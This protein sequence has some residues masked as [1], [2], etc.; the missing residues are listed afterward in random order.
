MQIN[1]FR[2]TACSQQPRK[3]KRSKRGKVEREETEKAER[4]KNPAVWGS[5]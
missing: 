5:V 3:D 4:T 2:F 1:R